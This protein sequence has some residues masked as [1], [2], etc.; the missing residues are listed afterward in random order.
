MSDAVSDAV[1]DAG[2]AG[3]KRADILQLEKRRNRREAVGADGAYKPLNGVEPCGS[4]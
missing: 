4:L 2:R 1:S 3:M